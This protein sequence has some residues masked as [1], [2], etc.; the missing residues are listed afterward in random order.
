VLGHY[1]H[2]KEVVRSEMDYILSNGTWELVDQLYGCKPISLSLMI[3]L[4]SIRLGLWPRVI[5]RK[6]VKIF[7]ILTHMLPD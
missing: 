6:K 3:L 1:H 7:F 2:W 4:T 5:H